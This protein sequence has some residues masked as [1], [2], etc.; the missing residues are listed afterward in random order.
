MQV[1]EVDVGIDVVGEDVVDFR[2]VFRLV[3]R[4]VEIDD[5]DFGDW[6]FECFGKVCYEDFGDQCFGFLVCIVEF[7]DEEVVVCI[8]DGGQ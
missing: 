1:V 3:E 7:D 4:F 8:D 2:V 5:C 6:Q